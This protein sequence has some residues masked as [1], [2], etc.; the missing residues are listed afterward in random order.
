MSLI[1]FIIISALQFGAFVVTTLVAFWFP[2]WIAAL[3]ITGLALFEWNYKRQPKSD[4]VGYKLAALL[5]GLGFAFIIGGNVRMLTVGVVTLSL[6]QIGFY[7]VRSRMFDR[8]RHLIQG[9]ILLLTLA[10][11]EVL[12]MIIVIDPTLML[13]MALATLLIINMAYAMIQKLDPISL[14]AQF[15]LIL[16]LAFSAL[17]VL[18][19]SFAAGSLLDVLLSWPFHLGLLLFTSSQIVHGGR[20]IAS[21]Q[22]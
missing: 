6:G 18:E 5:N 20:F 4:D 14:L 12:G 15:L 7:L 16:A 2:G 22:L 10:V 3:A 8:R 9:A 19:A 1:I 11:M 17:K 21:K 13:M